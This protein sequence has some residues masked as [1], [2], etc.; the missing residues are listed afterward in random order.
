MERQF[1]KVTSH[2]L[3][4]GLKLVLAG[5]FLWII[6]GIT[7]RAVIAI[8]FL[9]ALIGTW[10][11]D[12]PPIAP[13]A[14][15]VRVVPHVGL[16]LMIL[17]LIKEDEWKRLSQNSSAQWSSI[18][19]ERGI[20]AIVLSN[21]AQNRK[22]LDGTL[23][24]WVARDPKTG[25]DIRIPTDSYEPHRI[26]YRQSLDFLTLRDSD[27]PEHDSFNWSPQFFLEGGVEGY[28]IGIKVRGNWWKANKDRIESSGAMD[29]IRR[30]RHEDYLRETWLAFA[31]LPFDTFFLWDR[32]EWDR[33]FA[34]T[35]RK[36]FKEDLLLAGWSLETVG[37]KDTVEHEFAPRLG[38]SYICSCADVSVRPLSV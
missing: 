28:E 12:E 35:L 5:F 24:H 37:F 6:G 22:G 3:M 30:V 31:V 32:R 7:A 34:T 29:D 8:V 17:G 21:G 23:V 27:H 16:M 18:H 4:M 9:L 2:L 25:R 11:W 38:E 19:L 1:L 13:T 33:E 36:Q 15:E 20:T 10:D 26:E 14:Y